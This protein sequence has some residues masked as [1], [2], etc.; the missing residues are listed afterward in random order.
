MENLTFY[1]APLRLSL[2]CVHA[3]DSGSPSE[4]FHH[5]L[6]TLGVQ[7]KT[8]LLLNIGDIYEDLQR[9]EEGRTGK[10]IS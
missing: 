9:E 4:L 3:I 8:D 10:F 2:V 7:R 5:Q 6:K 1:T